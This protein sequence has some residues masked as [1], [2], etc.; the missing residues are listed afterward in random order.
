MEE[1]DE[2]N[3]TRKNRFSSNRLLKYDLEKHKIE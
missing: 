1:E 3:T 2:D